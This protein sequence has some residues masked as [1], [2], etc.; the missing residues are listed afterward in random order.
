M[1]II[2]TVPDVGESG[3]FSKKIGRGKCLYHIYRAI[4][5]RGN[6]ASSAPRAD[7]H[8]HTQDLICKVVGVTMGEAG[9]K[10]SFTVL[11]YQPSLRVA[12]NSF[13][14]ANRV[15]HYST[16]ANIPPIC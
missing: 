4:R 3:V 5:E 11:G 15:Q 7:T 16:C 10:F 2:R 12:F 9:E 14:R 13:P 8:P 1:V 6:N